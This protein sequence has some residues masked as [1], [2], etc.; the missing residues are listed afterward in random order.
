[1]NKKKIEKMITHNIESNGDFNKIKDKIN[2]KVYKKE[3]IRFKDFILSKRVLRLVC[4][5]LALAISIPFI[6]SFF[7]SNNTASNQTNMEISNAESSKENSKEDYSNEEISSVETSASTNSSLSSSSQCTFYISTIEVYG[8]IVLN[9]DKKMF[10]T[11]E[12]YGYFNELNKGK[13]FKY[14]GFYEIE[15]LYNYEILKV[16]DY[17]VASIVVDA[18]DSLFNVND[19]YEI[20]IIEE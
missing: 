1:M 15:H 13:E 8:V 14:T 5:L 6:P 9:E 20:R 4:P 2:Y 10:Y 11:D 19:I 7:K 18:G 17:C 16:D 3:K 12:G